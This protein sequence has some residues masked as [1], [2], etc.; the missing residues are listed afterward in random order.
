MSAS[1]REEFVISIAFALVVK[2]I[3]KTNKPFIGLSKLLIKDIQN[4]L[5]EYRAYHRLENAHAK[6]LYVGRNTASVLARDKN[7]LNNVNA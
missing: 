3:L 7:A 1:P 4:F 2:I 6:N 5:R